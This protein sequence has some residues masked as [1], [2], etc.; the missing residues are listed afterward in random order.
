M[1]E[2]NRVK[3]PTIPEK[4]WWLLRAKFRQSI[5]TTVSLGYLATALGMKEDSARSNILPSLVM[6]KLID[7]DG[8]PTDRA[9]RWRDDKEYPG[10]CEEIR[11]EIYP[12]ELLE[13]LPPPL[14][15]RDAVERWFANRTGVGTAAARRMAVVYELLCA[16]N[17]AEAQVVSAAPAKNAKKNTVKV[18]GKH[19][20]TPPQNSEP[21]TDDRDERKPTPRLRPKQSG[22]TPAIHINIQVHISSDSSSAQID[23]IFAS[24]AKYLGKLATHDDEESS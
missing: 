1:A 11:E 22:I 18:Y 2:N 15:D 20:T 16:A 6:S 14:P 21:V 9:K 7:P 3:Y 8:R 17:P 24:M 4:H 5:P 10:L 12:K 19:Q 13:A 23:Q